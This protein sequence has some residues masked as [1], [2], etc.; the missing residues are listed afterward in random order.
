MK[1]FS[2]KALSEKG[3]AILLKDLNSNAKAF[4]MITSRTKPFLELSFLFTRRPAGK[5][6]SKLIN[7]VPARDA[8]S[9]LGRKMIDLGAVEG[10]DF[11]IGVIA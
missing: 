10:V 9:H 8:L 2:I 5:L 4:T 3:E 6:M 1:G 7:M 11:E